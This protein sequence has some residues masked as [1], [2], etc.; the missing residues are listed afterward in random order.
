M[1]VTGNP[2]GVPLPP[3]AT[4]KTNPATTPIAENARTLP[5]LPYVIGTDSLRQ[6]SGIVGSAGIGPHMAVGFNYQSGLLDI[7][8]GATSVRGPLRLGSSRVRVKVATKKLLHI[9]NKGSLPR[10]AKH[11]AGGRNIFPHCSSSARFDLV[12]GV[13]H[14]FRSLQGALHLRL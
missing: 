11:L 8:R 3:H 14:T 9:G 4:R 13:G 10:D 6:L 7:K 1:I 12:D 5:P 2:E